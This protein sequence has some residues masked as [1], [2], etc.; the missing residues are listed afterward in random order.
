MDALR[1][2]PLVVFGR[3]VDCVELEQH[4]IKF[5]AET[6]RAG[7]AGEAYVRREFLDVAR[8]PPLGGFWKGALMT[9][10]LR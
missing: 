9:T 4:P 8:Q 6:L 1:E 2:V 3:I 7:E 5:R 10:S